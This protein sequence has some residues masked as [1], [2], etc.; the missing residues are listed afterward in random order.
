MKTFGRGTLENRFLVM[1]LEPKVYLLPV[2]E[3]RR[4][5]R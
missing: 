5:N 1:R 2:I 4:D 3:V